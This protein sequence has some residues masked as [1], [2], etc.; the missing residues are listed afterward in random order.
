MKANIQISPL[1]L[2]LPYQVIAVDGI[3]GFNV[4]FLFVNLG[5]GLVLVVSFCK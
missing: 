2:P 4:F 1:P 3:Q 5:M